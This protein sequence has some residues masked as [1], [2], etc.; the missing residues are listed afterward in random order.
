MVLNCGSFAKCLAPGYRL[1]WVAAGRFARDIQRRKITTTLATSIPIQEAIALLLR[2]DGYDA[3]LAKLRRTLA[4]QQS[5]ALRSLDRHMPPGYRVTRPDGGY[6]LWLE[7]PRS[8]NA[9]EIHAL[10]LEQGISIA[11]GPI[12]SP[13][14]EFQHCLR[15]NCGHP[16][17][18]ELEG[19]IA[20]LGGIITAVMRR[21]P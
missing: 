19:A 1:G 6:F 3:H 14:R 7:L 10:A 15:L 11:P 17:T 12:F 8:V 18:P 2:Q 4:L 5:A 20:T 9:L 16:W 13:R 21:A